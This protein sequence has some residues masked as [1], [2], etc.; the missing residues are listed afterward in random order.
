MQKKNPTK[1]LWLQHFSVAAFFLLHLFYVFL[2]LHH[3]RACGV[4]PFECIY[5]FG[6]HLC[7]SATVVV[8]AGKSAGAFGDDQQPEQTASLLN[9][10][11]LIGQGP[12]SVNRIFLII[13]VFKHRPKSYPVV[14]LSVISITFIQGVLLSQRGEESLAESQQRWSK[15]SPLSASLGGRSVQEQIHVEDVAVGHCWC[16]VEECMVEV[17]QMI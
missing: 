10:L 13:W 7:L 12:V 17:G 9:I 11:W 6:M 16:M 14:C 1:F 4:W 3:F 2:F 15:K 5:S 8:G